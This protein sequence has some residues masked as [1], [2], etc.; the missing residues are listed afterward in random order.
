MLKRLPTKI[1]KLGIVINSDS[2]SL[3]QAHIINAKLNV[4]SK[5]NNITLYTFVEDYAINAGFLLASNGHQIYADNTSII[6]GLEVSEYKLILGD[7]IKRITY[8]T[9][10][11]FTSEFSHTQKMDSDK[12]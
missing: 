4:L 7:M 11:S 5:K 1:Q 8:S 6:G 9:E 10:P 3:S 12:K 2:G